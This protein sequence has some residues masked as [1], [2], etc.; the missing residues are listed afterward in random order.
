MSTGAGS[1]PSIACKRCQ[2]HSSTHADRGFL[3]QPVRDTHCASKARRSRDTWTHD[4]SL[5]A[6][7]ASSRR[8]SW[9]LQCTSVC[10]DAK[11]IAVVSA[12]RRMS[13]MA[14]S[15][16]MHGK[17]GVTPGPNA[18]IGQVTSC[19]IAPRS[20]V[21]AACGIGATSATKR[22]TLRAYFPYATRFNSKEGLVWPGPC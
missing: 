20:T 15:P 4:D 19:T 18:C 8:N 5:T 22:T 2:V 10:V 16:P 9:R 17:C 12:F 21:S 3:Q 1:P 7:I 14:A 13:G 11:R 6:R